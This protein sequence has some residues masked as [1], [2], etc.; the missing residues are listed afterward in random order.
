MAFPNRF[1]A[2]AF[3][4][5]LLAWAPPARGYDP[6]GTVRVRLD[7]RTSDPRE[8]AQGDFLDC[9]DARGPCQAV[10]L[11]R[12][13]AD[14]KVVLPRN[15]PLESLR[16]LSLKGIRP[17]GGD[18]VMS[19]ALYSVP[20]GD[21]V[22]AD[23]N[24]DE[25]L[26][27]DGPAKFWPKG[28]SCVALERIGG[29][30]PEVL[31]CRA[32]KNAQAWKGKCEALKANV[33][34]AMC[35]Q[36]PIRARLSDINAGW[37]ESGGK[38]WWL[39]LCDADGDGRIRLDGG[40]RLVVDWDGDGAFS[41]SLEADGI[42]ASPGS[43]LRF[44]LDSISYE[45]AGADEKGGWLELRRLAAYDPTA[46][47]PKAMEGKPAPELRFVNMDGDTVRLSD[48]RGKK[49]LLHFW[50]TLCKPCLDNLEGVR[51]FW[52]SFG[53]KNWLVVS[54]TTET[55]LPS[56]QQAVLKRH[57]DWMVGMAGPE[58]RRYYANRP[59]PVIVKINEKGVVENKNL[60]LG[61]PAR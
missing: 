33:P 13:M 38:H 3:A 50:S 21:S 40:D 12:V 26:G 17:Q 10:L 20:S 14:E 28:D 55:D 46:A 37:L 60:N 57:M 7:E 31:L 32:G 48:L 23:L 4:A 58:A 51:G 54:L 22:Y 47:A 16:F 41:K 35:D 29:G 44:S 49:V 1:L 43:P 27:N 5:V 36:E 34:W 19:I 25:D 59:L 56:V 18:P 61:G 30:A 2:P 45:V 11:P 42:A 6:G 39:G 15:K 52:K 24:D 8:P 9:P 53:G